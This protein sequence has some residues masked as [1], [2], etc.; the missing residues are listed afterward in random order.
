MTF[1]KPSH[2]EVFPSVNPSLKVSDNKVR[3]SGRFWTTD[4]R[5]GSV[6]RVP[7]TWHVSCWAPRPVMFSGGEVLFVHIAFVMGTLYK[8]TEMAE[9]KGEIINNANYFQFH[10]KTFAWDKTYEFILLP[11]GPNFHTFLSFFLCW[12]DASAETS[13]C[14]CCFSDSSPKY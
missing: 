5:L 11:I 2:N 13:F 9:K 3:A 14:C 12:C 6:A 1:L 10:N 8:T 7:T 4:L